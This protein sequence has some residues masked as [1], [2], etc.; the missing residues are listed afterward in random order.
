M[1]G[2]KRDIS[3]RT[4]IFLAILVLA[5]SFAG[6]FA[7]LESADRIHGMDDAY[8]SKT[9]SRSNSGTVSLNVEEQPRIAGNINLE[10]KGNNPNSN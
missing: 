9:A 3:N 4:I 10:I 5:V 1:D 8:E 2:N 7:V 6:T